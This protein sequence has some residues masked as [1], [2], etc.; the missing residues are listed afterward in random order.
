VPVELT[1][2]STKKEEK[3]HFGPILKDLCLRKTDSASD[4]EATFFKIFFAK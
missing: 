1:G 2:F 4:Q 3:S